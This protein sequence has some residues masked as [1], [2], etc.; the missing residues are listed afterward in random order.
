MMLNPAGVKVHLAPGYTDLRRAST[1]LAP[2]SSGCWSR[3]PP[4]TTLPRAAAHFEDA[5]RRLLVDAGALL[6]GSTSGR[7][8]APAATFT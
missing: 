6:H 4:D 5:H 7:S 1:G 8:Q 3:I 2:W